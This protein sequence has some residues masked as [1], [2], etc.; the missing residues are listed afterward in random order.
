MS[1]T[2][3]EFIKTAGLGT[4]GLTFPILLPIDGKQTKRP[5][6]LFIMSDDHAEQAIS[7]YSKALI[8][9]PNI[10][11][12]ANE[13]I[14][15]KNS[16]VTNSICGPS[17]ATMLTGK[18][19]HKNGLRDNRDAFNG[20]QM[21]F[22]KLLQKAG[23]KTYMIG[24]W[25]LVTNPTGFDDWQVL[26]DQGEY[27]NPIFIE[28]G[29][30][31]K[32]TGYT[33]DII[34]DKALEILEKRDTETP[35]CMLVHHKAPH[36]NWMPNSKHLDAYDNKDLPLPETL[37]DDYKNRQAAK[38]ADMRIDDMYLGHDLKLKE[39]DFEKETGTGGNKEF[40]PNAD[41][42]W[43]KTYESLTEQQKKLW[44]AHYD[45]ISKKF[46]EDNL[47]GKDLTEWKY[48][49]YIKD[50]LSCILSVDENVGRLLDYLDKHNLADDTIVIYTSDQGFYLG[51]HGWYDKRF[52]YEESLGMPLVVRYPKEIRPNQVSEEMVLNLDFAPTFLDFAG[53]NA[54]QEMQGESFRPILKGKTP[55]D[56]RT[57]MY[58]HYYEYPHGWHDVKRHY[59]I[60]TER[61]K[62]IHFY[63]DIDTW[64]LY[65]LEKDPNE[66][67]NL[68]TDPAYKDV[69]NELKTELKKLQEKY[70]DTNPLEK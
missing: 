51:E 6:I 7:C 13:G 26:I 3:R 38:E 60:R 66:L 11:R 63:N 16:F 52:M 41:D 29:V 1:F 27:Y 55:N 25:H 24:K 46:K 18:Y 42:S 34:T 14:M 67:N 17:R 5:N 36:R 22:T 28:N 23:Y 70:G 64:E 15:F 37:F 45:R 69:L 12:I 44:D 4:V 31:K 33:T 49:R 59:G 57:S 43:Q 35:F 39:G 40:A 48:Q 56:W 9:T 54:P 21:T 8:N 20:E 30:N 10:D 2:R 53:V 62:L 58:Y 50:Y 61:Y 19:S 32:Y 68:Y 65:D 47:Q